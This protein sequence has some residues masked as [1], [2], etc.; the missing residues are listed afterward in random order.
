MGQPFSDLPPSCHH[1]SWLKPLLFVDAIHSSKASDLQSNTVGTWVPWFYLLLFYW[2]LRMISSVWVIGWKY[3]EFRRHDP[4]IN[5]HIGEFPKLFLGNLLHIIFMV[6]QLVSFMQ[7]S[8]SMPSLTWWLAGM[9]APL[10]SAQGGWGGEWR[11]MTS[12]F[13]DDLEVERGESLWSSISQHL[14]L[15]NTWYRSSTVS[16]LPRIYVGVILSLHVFGN[17]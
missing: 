6:G 4:N 10:R 5:F 14:N 9:E 12:W 15:W 16:F 17:R 7:Q 13:R 2:Y 11:S 1:E 8:N 3:S